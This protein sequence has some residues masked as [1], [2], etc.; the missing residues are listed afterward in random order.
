MNVR[1]QLAALGI[2]PVPSRDQFFLQNQKILRQIADFAEI[3][4][5]DVVLE[6]G[7]GPGNLTRELAKNAGKVIGFEIDARFAPL[8][9]DLP[10][11][12]EMHFE[13]A[14]EYVQLHGK[15]R[16]SKEYNK[17]VSNLPYSFA[18]KFLHNLTFLNY[19]K[20]ILL[21]PKSFALSIQTHGVF[22]SFFNVEILLEIPPEEFYPVPKT[23]S[24]VI[25][26]VKLPDPVETKNLP[27]FL[28]QY[29]YQ[30][31]DQKTKNSLREGLI[32]FSKLALGKTITKN[33]ANEFLTSRG[34][35]TNLLEQTP[36]DDQTY[37]EI[38]RKLIYV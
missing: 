10:V 36:V 16:K 8:L 29:T 2:I 26:L 17:I 11:N 22:A 7:V 25:D 31:E 14:W 28:R 33:Q 38:S 21:V 4:G 20:A 24:V 32:D 15:F 23:N 30:R 34:F 5:T 12:V 6:V 13:D 9:K 19:D 37:G 3:Q 18:E 1:N 27:I 35:S